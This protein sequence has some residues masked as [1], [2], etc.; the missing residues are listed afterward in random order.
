MTEEESVPSPIVIERVDHCISNIAHSE[1]NNAIEHIQKLKEQTPT[2]KELKP[3][4]LKL[5]AI[6]DPKRL[7]ILYLL[8]KGPPKCICELE[9]VLAVKQPTITHHIKVLEKADLISTDKRGKWLLSSIKDE[10]ILELLDILSK[11]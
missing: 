10:K 11:K 7:Q 5:K 2:I 3:I 9:A 6:A 4:L 8:R 1:C